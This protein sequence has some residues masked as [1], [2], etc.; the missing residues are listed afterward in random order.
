M[1]TCIAAGTDE[2]AALQAAGFGPSESR[3]IADTLPEAL[4]LP[5][6]EDLGVVV[7]Q[8]ASARNAAGRWTQVSLADCSFFQAALD[9][10]REHRAVGAL[11]EDAYRAIAER[12]SLVNAVSKA[13]NAGS[14]VQGSTL[15]FALMCA[16]A[17]D[18]GTRPW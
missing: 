14:D 9:L 6:M 13:L 16:R 5:A 10:S 7:S 11:A 4:A 12:S 3:V 17:E 2:I 15:S 8:V 1:A 18:F